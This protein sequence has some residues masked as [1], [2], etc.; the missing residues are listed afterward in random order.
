MSGLG[1]VDVL[2]EGLAGHLHKGLEALG[3][4]DGQ[5]GEHAAVD[6]HAGQAKTLDE[7]VV[8]QALGAGGSV[9]ALDPQATEVALAGA[10]VAERVDA[11][12]G[13]LLLGLA[14]EARALAAVARGLLENGTTL[15]LG[16][17]SPLHTCHGET[18]W[19]VG[20]SATE[21]L[22]DLADVGRGDRLVLGQLALAAGGLDLQQVALVGL[23]AHE[24]AAA[25]DPEALLGTGVR[26]VLRHG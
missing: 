1:G 16:V 10:T 26:L 13:D 8:G 23:L 6:L 4:V 15:L 5:L 22:L 12:V 18:P 11:G 25:G 19:W 2:G 9:D 7:A 3:L 20:R 24:L 14:V 21:Q 17:N